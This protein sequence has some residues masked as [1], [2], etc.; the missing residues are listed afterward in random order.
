MSAAI[1]GSEV[2]IT[3]ESM[4][5]MNSATATIRGTRRSCVMRRGSGR[6]GWDCSSSYG[7]AGGWIVKLPHDCPM[8]SAVRGAIHRRQPKS[9]PRSRARSASPRKTP[10]FTY[11]GPHRARQSGRAGVG[12]GR[13]RQFS[14]RG[15]HLRRR[16]AQ[17][18]PVGRAAVRG[19]YPHPHHPRDRAQ[20][21]DRRLRH[22]HGDRGQ[23]GD[24]HGAGRRHRRHPPQSRAARAG[25]AGAPGQE[26]RIRHGGEPAHHPSR[27]RRSP[28]RSR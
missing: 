3:V 23:D 13:D 14:P 21:S 11:L 25:R 6:V 16:A 8:K 19:R 20:P 26:V 12:D 1:A 7:S 2:A 4:L 28:T 18:R 15:V 10:D 5:S 9:G 24:R 27:A 17:A 22:G